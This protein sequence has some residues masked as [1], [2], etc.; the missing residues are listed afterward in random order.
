MILYFCDRQMNILGTTSTELSKTL[1]LTD[2]L[3]TEDIET[4]VA[5]FNVTVPFA[6]DQQIK[7]ENMTAPGNYIL[8]HQGSENDYFTIIDSDVDSKERT[9]DIYAED[10]GL[11]L[12]NV[13]ALVYPRAEAGEDE[14]PRSLTWYVTKWLADTGFEIGANESAA[15]TKALTW[16]SE[17]TVA[18]RLRDIADKFGYELSYSFAITGLTVTHKYVDIRLKRGANNSVRLRLNHEIEQLTVKRSVADLATALLAYGSTVEGSLSGVLTLEGYTYDDG[19][20]YVDGHYLKSRNAVA[21]WG[22]Y[23]NGSA[24]GHIFRTFNFDTTD[25]TELFQE[26]LKE[27]Q[28]ICDIEVNY[29]A[30]ISVDNDGIRIGDTVG[31]IDENGQN[32]LTSRVLKL[33]TSVTGKSKTVTLGDYLIQSG[34]INQ[35]VKELAD[36]FSKI[37]ESRSFYTWVAYADSS[38]GS[39]ISLDPTGKKYM[40]TAV[41]KTIETADITDPSVYTWALIQGSQGDK[42]AAGRGI[43]SSDISYA[44]S[45]SGTDAPTSGW[46]TTIPSV[47]AGHFLWTRTVTNY[48]DSTSVTTYSVSKIGDSGAKGDKGDPGVS[49]EDAVNMVITS[50]DGA[51]FKTGSI[52]TTLTAHV[53]KGGAEVTGDALTALGTIK[54]YK[55]GGTTVI[56][57]GTTLTVNVGSTLSVTTYTA[58]LEA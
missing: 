55:D 16:D 47:A 50:S 23:I 57:T 9:I 53:Y 56:G 7:A 41:N 40:G 36:Q 8:R 12:L 52:A 43:S 35:K 58:Q 31:I 18:E 17:Q 33:E 1:A 6:A 5:S 54:W 32:F 11:D 19:D 4:G 2:D 48:T 26:T 29:E 15:D 21:K 27:L 30:E 51:V 45:A 28:S 14:T 34:G 24:S 37:A 3:K 46:Q 44:E 10:A 49:G 22:R 38:A 20:F 42:G 39:G 13:Q 25:Q